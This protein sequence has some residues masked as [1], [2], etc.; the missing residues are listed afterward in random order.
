MAM[1]E[2]QTPGT[3]PENTIHDTAGALRRRLRAARAA[4][5]DAQRG[6]GSAA[7]MAHLRA[8]LK[9]RVAAP[10]LPRLGEAGGHWPPVAAFW[11]LAH[12]P[13][14]RPL[15]AEWAEA[16]V[17][18]ALPRVER[19][20]HPLAFV[21]WTPGAPMHSGAYGI[22]EPAGDAHVL[23]GIVLVP[24]LGY[25]A[26]GGRVGYGGGYYD[27]TLAAWRASGHPHVAIGVAW[28]GARLR[29]GEYVFAAHDMPLDA[30]VD[31]DGWHLPAA[32][33]RA[34]E[35]GAGAGG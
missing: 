19:V 4:L 24:T 8:G 16:G 18:L 30:V 29:A 5:T 33:R 3:A 35:G 22:P 9:D 17:A 6:E 13:D 11:P 31:E 32:P 28:R 2:R 14:L 12:E 34:P 7:I 25:S 26:E 15:L 1:S 20:A 27:R 10:G 21:A 23:P